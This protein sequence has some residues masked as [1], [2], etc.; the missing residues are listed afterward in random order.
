MTEMEIWCAAAFMLALAGLLAGAG[1][2]LYYRRLIGRM[3]GMLEKYEAGGQ[4]RETLAD[5]RESRLEGRL[6]RLLRRSAVLQEQ[7]EREHEKLAQLLSDLSHQLKTPLANIV[8]D[9]EL[10]QE[11]G[12]SGGERNGFLRHLGEQTKKLQWLLSALLKASRLENG[13]L[14]F[15]AKRQ[16]ILPALAGSVSAVYG[17][18]LEKEITIVTRE[19]ETRMLYHNRK[20]TE[21]ALANILENA[22]KYSPRGSRIQVSLEPLSIYTKINIMDQGPGVPQEEYTRIF[23]RFYRGKNGEETE[24]TGLGL[25]LAQVILAQEKGYVT[26][27][28]NPEG[29]SCFSVFLLN[30]EP[31]K[32][33]E[34]Y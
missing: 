33:A 2:F 22:V 11:E 24:G 6:R 30:E 19:S 7:A 27:S 12:L 18:A 13:F 3:E 16:D 17:Q 23:Q 29:G 14:H 32:P 4:L 28:E 8:M 5:T 1:S 34:K 31:G 9:A 10:L 25:Y 21:E 26:V 15:Q 20:W